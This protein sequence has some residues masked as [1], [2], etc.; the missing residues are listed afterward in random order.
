[1]NVLMA[2]LKAVALLGALT[3]VG[4]AYA[5]PEV[6]E[7]LDDKQVL[8]K[9]TN[10]VWV[11]DWNLAHSLGYDGNGLMTW[12]EADA[13]IK[14]LNVINYAGHNSWRLPTTNFS[15]SSN[16]SS[17]VPG[18]N[19]MYFGSGCTGS[20]MGHLYYEALGGQAPEYIRE[21]ANMAG[22]KNV[23]GYY[24]WSGTNPVGLDNMAGH[25]SMNNGDQRWDGKNNYLYAMAV[26]PGD[27]PAV[28]ESQTY[29]MLLVGLA[30]V[31]LI[32]R[33]RRGHLAR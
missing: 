32:A 17:S 33:R 11:S 30:A 20:E 9:S 23:M 25:F 2:N 27:V 21:K 28:P 22:F 3:L 6:L 12:Y 24:Y 7:A 14:R 1:M 31:G 18:S 5:G 13:W 26:R 15:A 8:D 16:C 29:A 4:N 19:D 10:L